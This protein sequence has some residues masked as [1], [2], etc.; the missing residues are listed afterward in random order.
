MQGG[1]YYKGE[2]LRVSHPAETRQLRA[3]GGV[4]DAPGLASSCRAATGRTPLEFSLHT[5]PAVRPGEHDRLLID[6]S[7]VTKLVTGTVHVDV[8]SLLA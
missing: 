2:L 1:V 5:T 3:S 8:T 7:I 4:P 6:Y